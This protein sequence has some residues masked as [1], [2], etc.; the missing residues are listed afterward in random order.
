[1]LYPAYLRGQTYLLLRQGSETGA[2]SQ[3]YLDH[4]GAVNCYPLRAL[5][6]RG[7][8]RFYA[9]Q[10]D[11]AQAKAAYQDFLRLWKDSDR[12]RME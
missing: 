5:A 4:R 9:I 1:M 7:L 11:T 3:K 12:P 10:G 2:E 8:A 6:L